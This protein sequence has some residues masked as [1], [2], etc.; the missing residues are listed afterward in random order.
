MFT[1]FPLLYAYLNFIQNLTFKCT[2]MV[3]KK[4][5]GYD[6]EANTRSYKRTKCFNHSIHEIIFTL[7]TDWLRFV[8]AGAIPLYLENLVQN[9]NCY[10]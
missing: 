5:R 4:C 7:F 3:K 8:V 9:I 1:L 6:F 2:K 10:K